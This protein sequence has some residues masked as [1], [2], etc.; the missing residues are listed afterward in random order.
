MNFQNH[1]R[2]NEIY[3]C[4]MSTYVLILNI[5]YVLLSF[6][7]HTSVQLYIFHVSFY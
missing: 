1:I 7:F 2:V 5:E 3:F 6:S 4:L